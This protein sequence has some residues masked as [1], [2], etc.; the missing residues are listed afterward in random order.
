MEQRKFSAARVFVQVTLASLAG[1]LLGGLFAGGAAAR[2]PG[3]FAIFFPWDIL[4]PTGVAVV[5]GAFGG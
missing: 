1:M 5:L 3:V 2:A 4:E